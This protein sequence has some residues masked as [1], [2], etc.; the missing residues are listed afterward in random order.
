[1]KIDEKVKIQKID[2]E[3]LMS[4]TKDPLKEKKDKARK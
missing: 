1:M 4:R 3:Y 2:K